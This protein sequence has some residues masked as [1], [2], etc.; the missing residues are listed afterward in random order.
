MGGKKMSKSIGNIIPLRHAIEQ[1]GADSI[2]LTM[3]A[4]AEILQDSVFSFDLVKG[5]S[6]KLFEIY[7]DI[8]AHRSIFTINQNSL[9]HDDLEDLWI[10]SRIQYIILET[11]SAIEKFRIREALHSILYLMD[12]DLRWYEKRKLA[13]NKSI[14]NSHLKEFLETRIKLLSPFAPFF[15]EEVWEIMGNHSFISLAQWPEVNV[16]EILPKSEDNERLIQDMILDIQKIT[17]VTKI[18][19]KKIMIYTASTIKSILYK[20][21]L[22][23]IQRQSTANFGVIMKEFVNDSEVKDFV[24]RT[25]DLVKKMID[26]ILSESLEVRERRMKIDSFNELIP[27]QDAISLLISE[28]GNDELEV[29]IYS[30]DNNE[31]YDPKQKS[32]FARPYKPAIYIE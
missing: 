31:K 19:P 4:S 15:C 32:K 22:D 21:L 26:D 30:E 14:C 16:S 7:R 27:L 23:K 5:I 29:N 17:K 20:K 3:L 25:P 28:I 12:N 1:Y 9:D 24:K 10:S 13:K 2:R 6:S 8:R 18:V 11:T